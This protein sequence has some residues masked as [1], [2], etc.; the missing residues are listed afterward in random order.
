VSNEAYMHVISDVL[1]VSS[2]NYIALII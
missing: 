1:F 2:S